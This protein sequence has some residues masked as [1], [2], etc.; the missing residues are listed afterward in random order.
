[1]KNE[2]DEDGFFN[3]YA[4]MLRSSQGLSGAG[5]WHQLKPM[6]PLLK[7][8]TVLDLG[9]GYGWHCKFSV[10][11]GAKRVLGI[12]LSRKMIDEAKT[13]NYDEKI[14]YRVC[15]LDEYEYP[16]NEW[17]CVISNLVFHYVED[18]GGVFRNI[19][20]TL[21][22]D[23]VFLFNI[24]HPVFTAGVG[25]EWI[26]GE[27]K[28]PLYWPVDN[29]FMSGER[30]TNFLGYCVTKQHHTLTQIFAGLLDHGF[31]IEKVEEARPP[32]DMM[33]LSGMKDEL[34]RPM[35]LLIKA[36]AVKQT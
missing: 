13:R 5:E 20:R 22:P 1:M 23:G 27:D 36:K 31:S 4:K 30:K 8:K 29:Y 6:F 25:Q 33:E 18:L 24:E 21:R 2:Y 15:G 28:K 26:Y 14:I 17:D 16:E 35:M 3:Q 12:D 9:C 11:Q 10:E 32:E 19:H 34:R 7:G